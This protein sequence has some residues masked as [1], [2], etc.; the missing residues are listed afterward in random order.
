MDSIDANIGSQDLATHVGHELGAELSNFEIIILDRL[1]RVPQALGHDRLCEIGATLEGGVSLDGHDAGHDG[2]GDAGG[3][4][5]ATPVN[6][7]CIGVE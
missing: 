3:T 2:N 1:E 4:N 6:E 5:S 7:N